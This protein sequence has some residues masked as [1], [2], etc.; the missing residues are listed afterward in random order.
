VTTS[1]GNSLR[2][3]WRRALRSGW[4]GGSGGLSLGD[5]PGRCAP[6]RRP[7]AAGVAT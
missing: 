3:A 5:P 4:P 2:R 1:T 7:R 6:A